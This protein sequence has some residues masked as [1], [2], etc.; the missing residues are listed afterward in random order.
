[1]RI[2]KFKITPQEAFHGVGNLETQKEKEQQGGGRR[3]G[4]CENLAKVES[5]E[6]W[7]KL[8]KH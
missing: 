3:N 7:V 8:R 6:N 5:L 4:C 2:H 1:M